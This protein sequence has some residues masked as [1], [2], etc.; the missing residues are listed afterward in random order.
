[1]AK[2]DTSGKLPVL[3]IHNQQRITLHKNFSYNYW[4]L[5]L[6]SVTVPV[7]H[8]ISTLHVDDKIYVQGFW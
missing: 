4:Y 3:D 6:V 8:T 2:L 5:K 1:L 7:K